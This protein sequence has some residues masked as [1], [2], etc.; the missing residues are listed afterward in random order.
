[1]SKCRRFED[2]PPAAQDYV[3]F[4]EERVSAPVILIGV[5]QGREDTI[6]RGI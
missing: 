3:R 4:I 6:L 2:L 1:M 5:G